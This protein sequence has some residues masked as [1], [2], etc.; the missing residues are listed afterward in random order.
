MLEVGVGCEVDH[1]VFA[2]LPRRRHSREALRTAESL[3]EVDL[4]DTARGTGKSAFPDEVKSA[5][6]GTTIFT[7][8]H[9]LWEVIE[10]IN[11]IRVTLI[12]DTA[13]IA[14]AWV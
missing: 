7:R 11:T 2:R 4:V 14:A 13:L 1:A 9:H 12:L 3:D 5:L 8:R 10:T 6:V